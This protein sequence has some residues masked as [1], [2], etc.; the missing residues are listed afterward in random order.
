MKKI[1]YIIVVFLIAVSACTEKVEIELDETYTRLV[2]EAAITTDTMMHVVKLSKTTSYYYNQAP[3]PVTEAVVLLDDNQ[4]EV[5]QLEE[6]EDGVYATSDDFHAVVGKTYTLNIRLNE[7]VAGQLVY[8]AS[9]T[10]QPMYPVDSIGLEYDEI[11][12]FKYFEVQCF[13]LDPPTREWYMFDIYKN[14]ERLTDT[15]SWRD[16]TDDEFFNGNYTNGIGVGYLD[17]DYEREKLYPGDTI[18][19][20]AGFITEEYA[21]FIWALQEEVNYSMPL[22]SGP[23]ANVIGNISNGGIGYFAVFSVAYSTTVYIE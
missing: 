11:S 3:P 8:S 4:G 10:V 7:G 17:Q 15:I 1:N 16:V 2:V 20:R 18:T 23:P 19:F 5:L 13:Y 14:G 22:F 6:I 9:S 12:D 21:E